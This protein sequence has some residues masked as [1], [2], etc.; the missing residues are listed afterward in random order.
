MVQFE[1]QFNWKAW[2]ETTELLLLKFC[3]VSDRN[4]HLF[5]TVTVL[6]FIT[7]VL[8][9]KFPNKLCQACQN[10]NPISLNLLSLSS[11]QP[12]CTL[13][14][15]SW[16]GPCGIPSRLTAHYT[17]CIPTQRTELPVRPSGNKDKKFIPLFS[18]HPT[19]H[20][21]GRKMNLT[22]AL[23]QPLRDSISFFKNLSQSLDRLTFMISTA[24]TNISKSNN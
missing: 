19:L 4:S 8:T 3:F 11:W 21:H 7:R 14:R 10:W 2:L 23:W 22:Q 1:T 18:P 16:L 24:W 15:Y 5:L 12:T 13:G 17:S 6:V 9:P 20:F